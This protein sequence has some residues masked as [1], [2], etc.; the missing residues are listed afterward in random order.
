[1]KILF[2]ARAGCSTGWIALSD[3]KSAKIK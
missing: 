3:K 1:M 2:T